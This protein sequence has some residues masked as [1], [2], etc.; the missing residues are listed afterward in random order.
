[1]GGGCL[2]LLELGLKSLGHGF[3]HPQALALAGKAGLKEIEGGVELSFLVRLCFDF[4][5]RRAGQAIRLVYKPPESSQSDS[6]RDSGTTEENE[7]PFLV[8]LK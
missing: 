7:P 2:W 4:R 5:A 1:M 6:V 3:S 8:G